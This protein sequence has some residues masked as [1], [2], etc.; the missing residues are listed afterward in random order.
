MSRCELHSSWSSP[1]VWL[2]SLAFVLPPALAAI[3]ASQP[4]GATVIRA[5]ETETARVAND[6]QPAES[7]IRAAR[8]VL[9]DIP[10]EDS[11][12]T[13]AT[14]ALL[15]E[16]Q[17]NG[18]ADAVQETPA[19]QT[20]PTGD[21]TPDALEPS[22][23]AADLSPELSALRDKVRRVLLMHYPRHQN[24]RDNDPWEVMH[25][26]IAYGVDSQLF[27]DRPGGEKVNAVGWMC[28]NYPC[29]G[30]RMLFQNGGKVDAGRGVG[31]QGHGGQ[32]LAI[33]AQSY[34]M[35]DYPLLVEG[36]PFTLLD[37]IERE[38][39]TCVAGEELTFKLIAL[40]H[41]LDSDATWTT[42]D[43]QPW[44]IQR[45]IREELKAP[46]RGAACGGTHRLMGYSYAVK[47][48]MARDKP[49]DG[50]FRRAQ[51]YTRDYHRYTFSLQ[52]PDGSFS[53]SWFERGGNDPSIDRRL[54]TS[55]HILEWITFSLSDDE[56]RDPRM[57]KAADYLATLLLSNDG[58]TWEIGP[59]GHGL[60]ALALYNNRVFKEAVPL[61]KQP[62]AR[63]DDAAALEARRGA[64]WAD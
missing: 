38:K 51:V 18:D 47:K 48:R 54:K 58:H 28:Y 22:R 24:T 8:R 41:F 3:A 1:A 50:E 64:E 5:R 20:S 9:I 7:A 16:P 62:L 44:S 27:K 15:F 10:G 35:A 49:I 45:L 61:P 52:N 14:D 31:L 2:W 6:A 32:F 17:S 19:G 46:I 13:L 53:T 60:H 63:G 4:S 43:G 33:L 30:Q 39:E 25:A 36:K 37:L 11:L 42:P 40:A 56:L 23:S 12:S 26:I 34:V 29:E 21:A 55:G 57:I 59:L